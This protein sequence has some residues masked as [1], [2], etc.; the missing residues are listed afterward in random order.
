MKIGVLTDSHSWYFRDLCRAAG[1][2]QL[3]PLDFE[4]LSGS[5]GSSVPAAR[6]SV[7]WDAD[8]LKKVDALTTLDAV[9]VRTMPPGSLEQVVFRMD[10]LWQWERSGTRILNPPKAIEIAVDKYLG[11]VR[12]AEA[13][14]PVPPT[15]ACQGWRQGMTAFESLGRDVVVKPLF[16]GE[17]RGLMR[18][19]D[20]DLA[21]RTFRTLERLQAVMYLQPFIPHPGYDY[22][23]LVVGTEHFVIRR[24]ADADWRT[25]LSRGG[26]AEVVAESGPWVELGRAAARAVGAPFA[27]VD[28]LPGLDGQLYVLEVNAVAGWKGVQAALQIDVAAKVLQLLESGWTTD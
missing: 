9:L 27:G 7:T 23:V 10:L 26:H 15:I 13:G 2:R 1:G 18:V 4:Q 6:D 20:V 12:L 3:V 19:A 14:L 5:V 25:N 16:G 21:E 17:G 8:A 28:V 22:R 24:R 11:T